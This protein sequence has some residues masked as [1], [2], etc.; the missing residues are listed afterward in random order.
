MCIIVRIITSHWQHM[1]QCVRASRPSFLGSDREQA[2][3]GNPWRYAG[4]RACETR[5]IGGTE[6]ADA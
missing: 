3:R 6:R 4:G 2:V 5:F 1:F